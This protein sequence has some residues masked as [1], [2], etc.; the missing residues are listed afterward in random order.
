MEAFCNIGQ[1]LED[2][3]DI[4]YHG[5]ACAGYDGKLLLQKCSA[6]RYAVAL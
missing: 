5:I 6:Q 3:L 1:V 2:T 4:H